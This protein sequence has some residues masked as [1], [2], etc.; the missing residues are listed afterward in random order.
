LCITAQNLIEF[1]G[2]ATR[3][4]SMNGL[5][6]TPAQAEAKAATFESAFSLRLGTPDIDPAWKAL[7]KALAMIGKQV[8]DARLVAVCH[9]RNRSW[10]GDWHIFPA[11]H[12]WLST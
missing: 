5:G 8:R 1:R 4:T 12:G 3:P 7:V 2:V 9:V 6:L 10:G 11:A